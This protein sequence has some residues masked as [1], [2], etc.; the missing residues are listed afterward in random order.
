MRPKTETG[1]QNRLQIKKGLLTAILLLSTAGL[2]LAY[3]AA[4]L[5]IKLTT[6]GINGPSGCSYNSWLNCDT[7]LATDYAR[8]F[9]AP[10]AW[11]GFLF[12]VWV[13]A[14]IIYAFIKRGTAS[15]YGSILTVF[16][17][18]SIAVLFSFFKMYQLV[19]L[20]ALCPVC[21]AMYA[22]NFGIFIL[23]MKA[24]RISFRQILNKLADYVKRLLIRRNDEYK[25][26]HPSRYIVFVIWIFAMGFLGMK[27]YE[28]VAIKPAK[29]NVQAILSKHFLQAAVNINT[30]EAPV[31]GKPESK[32]TI[33]EFSDFECPACRLLSDILKNILLD[34]KDN[35]SLYYMNYP[36]DKSVNTSLNNEIHKNA[37]LAALAG[38]AAQN[39]NNFWSYHYELFENQ[40]KIDRDFL[41]QLAEEQ[42]MN[43]DRF[44]SDLDSEQ[45]KLRLTQHIDEAKNTGVNATPFLF[46]NGLKVEYWNS[47]EV[48]RAI[49]DEELKK[50]G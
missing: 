17:I 31:T 2:F 19:T 29:S 3:Y 36:L 10:V 6:T 20:G 5:T 38:L 32:V 1:E 16:F 28:N 50:N 41:I 25:T 22:V 43:R 15:G 30:F 27:Y 26:P 14:A 21:A 48:I 18:S 40:T 42:G 49:I 37:G 47:P 4:V 39:Q 34:Y 33:I 46:I 23:A 9:G 12:Y 24:A 35:V 44:I 8:M 13:I 45:T 7:V 11:W